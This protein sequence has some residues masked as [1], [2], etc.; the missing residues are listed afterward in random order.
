MASNVRILQSSF[1]GGEV[2]PEMFGRIDDVKYQSGLALCRNFIIK[3]QGPAENRAGFGFVCE[4]KDS[5]RRVKLITFTYSITQTMVIEMGP[6][7]MRFHTEGATLLDGNG[8]PYEIATPYAEADLFG[9]RYVQSA[10]VLTLV[11]PNYAPRELRRLGAALWQLAVI[12]FVSPV[13]APSNVAAVSNGKGTD[14]TYRYVVTAMDANGITESEPSA[15]VSCVNNLFA[16]GAANTISWARSA[17]AP[18]PPPPPAP[19]APSGPTLAPLTPGWVYVLVNPGQQW[20]ILPVGVP[21]VS[22]DDDFEDDDFYDYF[23]WARDYPRAGTPIHPL[24]TIS[25]VQAFFADYDAG[26]PAYAPYHHIYDEYNPGIITI[27]PPAPAPGSP[28]GPVAGD[29]ALPAGGVRYNVYKQ[30]GGLYGYI[31]QTHGT[32][33]VDDNIAPDMS[34][35]PPIYDAVFN[36][37]GNYPGAVSYFEQRRVFASTINQPQNIWMT[38]SGTES[39]MSYSLPVRDDDRVAFRVAAREASAVRHIVPLTEL[40]LLTSSGE[41]RVTSASSDAVTPTS[42]NV[43]PQSYV[44]ANDVQPVVVN[45]T[46]IYS[47]ARGGHAREL[48]Y[49]WQANGFVTNDLSLRAAHL[50]DNLDIVDMA[51]AKAP[52]PVVWCVSSSGKL[53]GLTYVPEQ[54]IGAWH[55]H[56]TD[57]VFESC[58]VVAE[59]NED[60]LYV[61]VRRVIKGRQV[62]YIERM[63][64][65][66]FTSPAAAFFVDCGLTYRGTPSQHIRG[67][68]HLEG[69]TVSILAD[70]TVHPPR[71][72]KGGAIDLDVAA[73]TVHVGLPIIAEIETLPITV[74]QL[75]GGFGKGRVKNVNRLSLQVYRSS[76][77]WVGPDAA[78]LTEFKPRTREPYGAAPALKSEEISLVLS[79]K[80]CASGQI[81]VRQVDPLPLTIVSIAAEVALGA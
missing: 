54:Q 67:L 74:Q 3:P 32:S 9:I 38:R 7:Y 36:A 22:F 30:Q 26:R 57:G 75:D 37:A 59:G 35:T 17:G 2:S 51:Y 60:R 63:A 77:I 18:P 5:S 6:L 58:A 29:P 21:G 50:F 49:N 68:A 31:G 1:G 28:G 45:N 43:R 33:L 76:G 23:D 48:A 69:R 10:D 19:P 52:Q 8:A 39:A 62:R 20:P 15:V 14:Y 44:G 40:L 46:T 25:E 61:V 4:A 70:G 80:W 65:R 27:D 64:S 71:V 12:N 34:M 42:I 78:S 13:P 47:A 79:G 55:Q 41:W 73:S 11:H 56:D 72:V 24:P 16:N 66:R 53:L 81:L